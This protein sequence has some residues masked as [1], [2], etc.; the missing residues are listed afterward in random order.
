M[1]L[2]SPDL[3]VL[4]ADIRTMDVARPRAQALLDRFGLGAGL[5]REVTPRLVPAVPATAHPGKVEGR[6]VTGLY[7]MREE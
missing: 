1:S 3:I 6:D 5:P 2:T 4:N 7:R